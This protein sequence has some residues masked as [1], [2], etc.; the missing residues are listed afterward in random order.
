LE[1]QLKE[2]LESAEKEIETADS[3]SELLLKAIISPHAG[4]SYSAKT[5]AFSYSA[6]NPKN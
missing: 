4:F 1:K 2:W 5:A 3:S 6:I